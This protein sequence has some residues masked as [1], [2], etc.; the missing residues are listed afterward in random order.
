MKKMIA[1]IAL[2]ALAFTSSAF[3]AKTTK[4]PGTK[5]SDASWSQDRAY[6]SS[7]SMT[8]GGGTFTN[9]IQTNLS[10]GFFHSGNQCK[11]CDSGSAI[12][13]ALSYLRYLKDNF[14]VGGE[15][16][17]NI[18]S[19]E[20]SGTGDS[21][22]TFKI[23]G[24]G[25]YNFDADLKNALYAKLGVGLYPV[26]DDGDWETQFGFFLGGGKRFSWIGNVS[27]TPEL[28]LTKAGDLD[29]AVDIYFLNF[30]LLWN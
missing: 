27:Y 12:S 16:A 24:V 10:G 28:R 13:A 7:G 3:A 4:S 11:D 9:E 18:L 23:V 19:E 22:T 26:I 6:A 15:A 29:M 25:V 21:A 2:T 20:Y 1:A 17:I 8:F 30:S 14:Q 5:V